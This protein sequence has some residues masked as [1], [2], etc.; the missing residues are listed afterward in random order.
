M[1]GR[2][3]LYWVDL[4]EIDGVTS[5]PRGVRPVLIV[6]AQPFN[7]SKLRTAIAAAVTKNTELAAYPGNVFLPAALSRLA[8]DSV[9]NVTQLVTLDKS[10]LQRPVGTLPDWLMA[11]VDV[12]VRLALGL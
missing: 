10:K 5:E 1:I 7:A 4:G 11:E 2:G 8:Y 3:D 9:V 12:G 6:S